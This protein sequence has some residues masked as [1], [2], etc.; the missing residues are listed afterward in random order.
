MSHVEVTV[1]VNASQEEV[2][3]VVSDPR[4]L[5]RWDRHVTK[6]VG[7]PPGGLD[8]G[9]EYTTRLTFWGISAHVEAEVLEF[10]PPERSRIRLT[11]PLIEAMVTTEVVGIDE[12]R[13]SIE[14]DIEYRFRGGPLGH[15]AA[16]ALEASG[17]PAYVLRRGALAQK[18]Q[19]EEG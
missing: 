1:E 17:G 9:T 14:H 5:P 15:I 16:R 2:W 7:V 19:V 4:N 11:G 18:R 8:A 13:S 6:V 12:N 10:K 3:A